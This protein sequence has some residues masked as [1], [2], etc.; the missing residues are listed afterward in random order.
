MTVLY[1]A[2]PGISDYE[3]PAEMPEVHILP[4]IV[5][6][7][8]VCGGPCHIQAIYHPD[9]GLMIDEA[10]MDGGVYERS[11]I[12]HELVHHAQHIDGKFNELHTACERRAAAEQEAFD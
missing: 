3:V 4:R 2:L 12:F 11:I 8:L 1:T 6:Q 5:L 9:F 7:D 10:L